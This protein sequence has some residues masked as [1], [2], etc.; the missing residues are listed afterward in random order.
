MSIGAKV[1][2]VVSFSLVK[3]KP[4]FSAICFTISGL[5]FGVLSV[6]CSI[7]CCPLIQDKCKVEIDRTE[8]TSSAVIPDVI[9]VPPSGEPIVLMNDCQTT[10]GYP[11]I[12]KVLNEDLGR[13]AQMRPGSMFW[14]EMI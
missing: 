1:F 11:R 3:V 14:F 5:R 6:F 8:I 2:S 4:N 13:L 9:Q 10:G 12:A 7:V